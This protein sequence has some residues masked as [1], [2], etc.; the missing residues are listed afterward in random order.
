VSG[1]QLDGDDSSTVK[2]ILGFQEKFLEFIL[3]LSALRNHGHVDAKNVHCHG[4]AAPALAALRV[5]INGFL[6]D[7]YY[8]FTTTNV[9]FLALDINTLITPDV[10]E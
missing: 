8:P 2:G 1:C 5:D 10:S 4:R 3:A 7:L 9:K 6:N